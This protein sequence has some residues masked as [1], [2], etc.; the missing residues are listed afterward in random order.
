MPRRRVLG[1]PALI[2]TATMAGLGAGLLGEGGAW[3]V[4]ASAGLLI[5]VLPAVLL[6][7][8]GQAAARTA[9]PSSTSGSSSVATPLS[10]K[11]SSAA[12]AA[13]SSAPMPK[14]TATSGA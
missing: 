5:P 4:L 14:R 7:R 8:R 1:V 10:S 11:A 3:D 6:R 13:A 12:S 2:A 9:S